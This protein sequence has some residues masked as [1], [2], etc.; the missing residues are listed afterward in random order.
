MC[1]QLRHSF[2]LLNQDRIS[3]LIVSMLAVILYFTISKTDG[4][5][6]YSHRAMR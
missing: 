1:D 4:N 2:D 6:H 5:V 3:S